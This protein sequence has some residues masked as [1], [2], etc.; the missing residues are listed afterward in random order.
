MI[1]NLII[2]V[3]VYFLYYR[4]YLNVQGNYQCQQ[5]S[6]YMVYSICHLSVVIHILLVLDNKEHVYLYIILLLM[7]GIDLVKLGQT[8]N[9]R[10]IAKYINK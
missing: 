8:R 3:T 1:D 4:G 10:Y 6:V 2:N 7:P 5:Y 9:K